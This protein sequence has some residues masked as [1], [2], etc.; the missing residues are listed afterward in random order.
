MHKSDEQIQVRVGAFVAVGLVF[1]LLI[2]FLLG[3]EKNLFEDQYELTARFDDI[4]GLRVGAPVQLAGINVGTVSGINFDREI[5]RKKVKLKLKI[6]E[7]YQ[8]RVREDSA[9]SIVNQGL[10]GDKLVAI[11]VGSADKRILKDGDEIAAITPI[12]FAELLEKG[13]RLL[14]NADKSA[15]TVA[16]LLDEVQKGRGMIHGMIFDPRGEEVVS[17]L[18]AVSSNMEHV[19]GKIA[20]GEGTLGALINDPT[21]F[22]DMKTLIGKANRN[23]ILKGVVRWTLQTK[24]R[25]LLEQ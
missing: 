14:N 7:K 3:S 18:R 22:N 5:E 6:T 25:K 11:S 23:K 4:S 24:D 20:R 13:R 21:L 10:L 16:S 9:A 2:V 15:E 17:N 8:E 19:S 1:L 12:S